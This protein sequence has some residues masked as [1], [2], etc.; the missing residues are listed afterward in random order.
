LARPLYFSTNHSFKALQFVSMA[1]AMFAKDPTTDVVALTTSDSEA[2][3][4]SV[5]RRFSPCCLGAVKEMLVDLS[6]GGGADG[7]GG[8]GGGGGA[9]HCIIGSG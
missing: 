8:G 7:G 1:T 9:V 6:W 2:S 4:T 3:V 5:R